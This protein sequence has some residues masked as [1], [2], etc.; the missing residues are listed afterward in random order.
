MASIKS[1]VQEIEALLQKELEEQGHVAF[2]NLLNSI[3]SDIEYGMGYV[4]I[5]FYALD[6]GKY[7]NREYSANEMWYIPLEGNFKEWIKLRFN[8]SDEK[9]I[10]SIYFAIHNKWFK[11]GKPTANS[12]KYSSNGYRTEW[13]DRVEA[14]IP[15]ILEDIG[16]T[17]AK[18]LVNGLNFS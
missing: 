3:S 17:A 9:E 6:Y 1:K 10:K 4:D 2:G 18:D 8:T 15:K 7:V 16:E 5:T 13:I 12:Y 14:K 11:E